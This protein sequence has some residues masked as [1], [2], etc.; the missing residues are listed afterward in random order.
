MTVFHVK[1]P[2][3]PMDE[4]LK[5]AESD[6]VVIDSGGEKQFAV[7]PLDD[8]LIDYLL[9]RQ[10]QFIDECRQIRDRMRSGQYHIHEDVKKIV[11]D[12][13]E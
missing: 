9:E 2:K 7:L 5:A 3:T 11:A 8:D 13:R 1:D 4:I 10:P 12:D 6:G